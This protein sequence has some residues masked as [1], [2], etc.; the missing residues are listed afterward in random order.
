MKRLGLKSFESAPRAK[1]LSTKIFSSPA[2]LRNCPTSVDWHAAL[3][4]Q[5]NYNALGNDKYGDCVEAGVLR[6]VQLREA[7]A[8]RSSWQPTTD[9]AINLYSQW[10]G[11]NPQTGANDNGTDI[12]VMQERCATDGISIGID[13]DVMLP[14]DVPTDTNNLNLITYNCGGVGLCWAL[15]KSAEKMTDVW[16][17]AGDLNLPENIPGSWGG[18][19]TCSGKY[20]SN[21][22]FIITWGY[23]VKVTPAFEAAYLVAATGA[24]SRRWF[25]ANGMAPSGLDWAQ[26]E[27]IRSKFE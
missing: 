16:D 18:H 11:F 27:A 19:F 23:E 26:I 20:D 3:N 21:S 8:E 12:S 4:L 15:P 13:L 25:K 17:V 1:E 24:L 9:L 6:L 22:R 7:N 14:F 10:S 5:N 2:N